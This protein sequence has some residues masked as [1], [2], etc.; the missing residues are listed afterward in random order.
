MKRMDTNPTPPLD[1]I[2]H[3]RWLEEIISLAEV[4]RL[5]GISIDSVRRQIERGAIEALRPSPGRVGVRRRHA[6]MLPDRARRRAKR[7]GEI[8]DTA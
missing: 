7:R 3:E 5:R 8:A 1:P 4:A 2:A 6:L